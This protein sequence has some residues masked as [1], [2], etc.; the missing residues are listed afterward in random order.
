MLALW[1]SDCS[2]IDATCFGVEV[3][4]QCRS[5]T[6]QYFDASRCSSVSIMSQ[7]VTDAT[8]SRYGVLCSVLLNYCIVI[9]S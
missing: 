2:S 3:M 1:C 9:N 7:L 5:V 8:D 6:Y 4:V